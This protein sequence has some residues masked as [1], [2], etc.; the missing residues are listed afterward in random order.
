MGKEREERSEGGKERREEKKKKAV[1]ARPPPKAGEVKGGATEGL[2]GSG[3]GGSVSLAPFPASEALAGEE[4]G[5]V[6]WGPGGASCE[7]PQPERRRPRGK[8]LQRFCLAR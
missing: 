6:L 2:P 8:D 4:E 7:E 1:L 5:S 3:L